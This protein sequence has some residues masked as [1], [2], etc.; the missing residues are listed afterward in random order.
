MPT[1]R[2]RGRP[3]TPRC[4]GDAIRGSPAR[5]DAEASASKD[6][7]RRGTLPPRSDGSRVRPQAARTTSRA[8]SSRVGWRSSVEARRRRGRRPFERIVESLR[9]RRSASGVPSG[10]SFERTSVRAAI[11]CSAKAVTR[12]GVRGTFDA[13]GDPS[14]GRRDRG[15]DRLNSQLDSSS[16]RVAERTK[17]TVLKTVSGATRS[18]VRIPALP[19]PSTHRRGWSARR[20]RAVWDSPSSVVERMSEQRTRTRVVG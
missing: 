6:G 18:R 9:M 8:S 16:G 1:S 14:A 11:P 7:G 13:D 3:S 10:V 17:A 4:D 12:S 2:R 15:P 20:N 5:D 19:P